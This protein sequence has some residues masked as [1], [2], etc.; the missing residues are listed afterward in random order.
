VAGAIV[1]FVGD[2]SARIAVAT[3]DA[4]GVYAL[5][6][7]DTKG[8][9]PGTYT[10]LVSK[11]ESSSAS[12]VPISMD[13]AAQNKGTAKEPKKLLPAKYADPA[14]SPLK[15]EVKKGQ[16]HTFDLPLAD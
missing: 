8:A 5:T 1:T 14:K 2:E 16:S 11:F 13:E 15:F 7:L 9:M 4:S 12:D 6:T 10:V 3:T